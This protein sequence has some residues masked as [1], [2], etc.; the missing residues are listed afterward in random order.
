[1]GSIA[2]QH[3]VHIGG[4]KYG[5]PYVVARDGTGIFFIRQE[6][7]F[8][9]GTWVPN[10]TWVMGGGTEFSSVG[11]YLIQDSALNIQDFNLKLTRTVNCRLPLA[12]RA[13][14]ASEIYMTWICTSGLGTPVA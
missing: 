4:D 9:S 5:R 14:T 11:T 6:G 13:G 7:A 10:G 3:P 1:M 12:Y 8:S 2:I